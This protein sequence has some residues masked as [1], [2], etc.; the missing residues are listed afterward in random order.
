[1]FNKPVT[2]IVANGTSTLYLFDS[3]RVPDRLDDGPR[4]LLEPG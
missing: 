1:M 3:A 2:N 4:G